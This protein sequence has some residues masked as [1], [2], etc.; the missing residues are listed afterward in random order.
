MSIILSKITTIVSINTGLFLFFSN[1][2][3]ILTKQIPVIVGPTISRIFVLRDDI[4]FSKMTEFG[5]HFVNESVE[6]IITEMNNYFNGYLS[7]QHGG[8]G[9]PDV[10]ASPSATLSGENDNFDESIDAI[11]AFDDAMASNEAASFDEQFDAINSH[12]GSITMT[13][14]EVLDKFIDKQQTGGKDAT[15]ILKN[16][17]GGAKKKSSSKPVT[18]DRQTVFNNPHTG[19]LFNTDIIDNGE[20]REFDMNNLRGGFTGEFDL[21]DGDDHEQEEFAETGDNEENTHVGDVEVI[22][23]DNSVSEG[24]DEGGSE[25]SDAS[26][27][28]ASSDDLDDYGASPTD[29]VDRILT[30]LRNR[31]GRTLTGGSLNVKKRAVLTDMYPYIIRS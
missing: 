29:E 25:E 12:T 13:D 26:D 3:F 31:A 24:S 17:T 1:Q 21:P 6:D 10:A 27:D 18:V 7:G 11:N 28:E 14:T 22:Q 9:V 20:P 5:S 15:E 16:M 2:S 8:G 4:I 30:Q 23:K 19:R